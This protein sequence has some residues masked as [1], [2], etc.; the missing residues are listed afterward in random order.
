LKLATWNV[1]SLAVRLPQ[2]LEWLAAQAATSPVDAVVLQETKLTDDKFPRAEI[3][4]A[5][6]QVQFH[7]QKTYNGVALLSRS[8]AALDVVKNIPGLDDA[9]ARVIA[10]TVDGVRIIGAYFPNGQA[11]DSDKFVYKMRWQDALHDWVRTELEAHPR[12]VLMGDFNI[13]PEDR[14]VYDPIGWAGQVLC[15]EQ[16][17]AH[18]QGLLALGLSDAFRLFEQPPKP[19]SWWDYRNLAFRKNQGLRIDHILVSDAL[20]PLVQ[21]CHI[22]KLPRKNE[23]PSDHAPVLAEL[24]DAG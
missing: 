21:S 9:Q 10:G 11:P 5:G 15:T 17:R 18:F 12:L 2:L 13:A 20:K 22:D 16:E 4:A 8:G 24:R 6:Y 19:W 14:D 7:G 1:N 3:E 23:R